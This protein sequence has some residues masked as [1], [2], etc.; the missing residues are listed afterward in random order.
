MK[1]ERT[2]Q[3]RTDEGIVFNLSQIALMQS[4]SRERF[5][6]GLARSVLV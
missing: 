2:T 3:Y 4:A 6:A 1:F 5:M